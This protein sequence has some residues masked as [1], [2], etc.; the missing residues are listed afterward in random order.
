M[1]RT[2]TADL[3]PAVDLARAMLVAAES[4]DWE[5]VTELENKR[6]RCIAA[7]FAQTGPVAATA[8][9]AQGVGELL[10]LEEQVLGLARRR[11]AELSNHLSGLRRSRH[12]HAAY[13]V[14]DGNL[15]LSTAYR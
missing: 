13:G 3:T 2:A 6:E 8:E 5:R 1:T 9:F 15:A 11:M 14:T 7:C 4:G 12:A 10:R